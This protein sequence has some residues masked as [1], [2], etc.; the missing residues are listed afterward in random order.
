MS[1]ELFIE[2]PKGHKTEDTQFLP[3]AAVRV[4]G[5]VTSVWKIPTWCEV[6]LHI[7]DSAGRSVQSVRTMTNVAGNFWWDI[8]LPETAGLYTVFANAFQY[9]NASLP[10]E[11]TTLAVGPSLQIAVDPL[12]AWVGGSVRITARIQIDGVPV[13]NAYVRFVVGS[14]SGVITGVDAWTDVTGVARIYYQVRE[15]GGHQVGVYSG[16]DGRWMTTSFS[17][18]DVPELPDDGEPPVIPEPLPPNGVEETDWGPLLGMV[19]MMMGMGLMF[20]VMRELEV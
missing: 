8:S 16:V 6:D 11:V 20:S 17:V 3:G 2:Y 13:Q 19:V 9:G 12:E 14:P 1:V 18:T 10:I 5:R 7:R 4:A 15:V